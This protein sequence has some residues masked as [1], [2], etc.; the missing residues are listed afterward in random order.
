MVTEILTK[1]E[2]RVDELCGIKCQKK[3]FFFLKNEAELK[4][5]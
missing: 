5:K 3:N 1:L 2:R 4:N